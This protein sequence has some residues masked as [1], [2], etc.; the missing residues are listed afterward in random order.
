[1]WIVVKYDKKKIG[2]LV[3]ELKNKFDDNLK[4]YNP[5]FKANIK[6]KNKTIENEF[7]LLRDYLFCYHK[8]FDNPYFVNILKF[9]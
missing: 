4:I 5:K 7:N 1:M 8:D 3:N 2:L 9:F 6:L